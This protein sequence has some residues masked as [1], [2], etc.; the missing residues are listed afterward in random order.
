MVTSVQ[1]L[2]EEQLQL[3]TI[4]L[5]YHELMGRLKRLGYGMGTEL[6]SNINTTRPPQRRAA[7]RHPAG[8]TANPAE[9]SEKTV[10][11]YFRRIKFS[12]T[13]KYP[14]WSQNSGRKKKNA[15][16]TPSGGGPYRAREHR[17]PPGPRTR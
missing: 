14:L 3:Q 15:D 6:R 1:N 5:E 12:K 4:L 2:A 8:S 16:E 13:L 7:L 10:L 11:D 17:P 9:S